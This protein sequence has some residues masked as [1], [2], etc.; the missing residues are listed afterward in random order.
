[1]AKRV[2]QQTMTLTID[3]L[4]YSTGCEDTVRASLLKDVGLRY[5]TLNATLTTMWIYRTV[6][7]QTIKYLSESQNKSLTL[8]GKQIICKL[9]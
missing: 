2:I 1:M 9:I 4:K 6:D 7:G 3:N 8:T 5:A